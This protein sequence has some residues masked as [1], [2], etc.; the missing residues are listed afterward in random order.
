ME[1]PY[2]IKL[3]IIGFA[4]AVDYLRDIGCRSNPNPHF[5][6]SFLS[7]PASALLTLLTLSPFRTLINELFELLDKL[8]TNLL[9]VNSKSLAIL[10]SFA[11]GRF[12]RKPS[13]I[14]FCTPLNHAFFAIRTPQIV[15]TSELIAEKI[16][17]LNL[18]KKI[19]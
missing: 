6:C 12:R 1:L 19:M 11:E 13:P 8:P 17:L 16:S 7:G 3:T 14:C 18:P 2:L 15:P 5:P 9:S 10:A 4:Y